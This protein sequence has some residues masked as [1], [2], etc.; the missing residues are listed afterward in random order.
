[1]SIY[2]FHISIFNDMMKL[3]PYDI[4]LKFYNREMLFII[5]NFSKAYEVLNDADKLKVADIIFKMNS[6]MKELNMMND[7]TTNIDEK[8]EF[9]LKYMMFLDKINNK[10]KE[11]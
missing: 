1:M 9:M 7:Y 4:F 10:L 2:D 3:A 8:L 11:Q 6:D 5:E